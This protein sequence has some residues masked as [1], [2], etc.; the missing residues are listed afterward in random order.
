MFLLAEILIAVGSI[1]ILLLANFLRKLAAHRRRFKDLPKPPHSFLF[2]HI[3]LFIRANKKFSKETHSKIPLNVVVADI[4]KNYQLPDLFVFDLWPLVDPWLMTGD[5]KVANQFLN[6]Y[7]RHPM[8]LD[9]ALQ[10]L[11]GGKR[12]LVSHDSAEWHDARSVIRTVFSVNNVQRYIPSMARYSKQFCDSL[13]KRAAEGSSFPMI[14]PVENWGADLTFCFL[15]G[16]DTGVQMGGRGVETNLQVQA[17]ISQADHLFSVNLWKNYQQKRKRDQCLVSVRNLIETALK[18]ALK[19]EQPMT[20]DFLC[21]TDSLAMKYKEEFPDRTEWDEDTLIQHLDTLAT[22]FLAADVSSMVLTYIFCHIAQDPEVATQ[23]REEHDAVFPGDGNATLRALSENP[24]KIKELHYTTAVIKESMRLRPPG[25]AGTK[26]PNGQTT[27]H[28][29]TEFNLDGFYVH[30]NPLP[31]SLLPIALT[32]PAY[33]EPLL[34]PSKPLLCPIP[35]DIRPFS[36]APTAQHRVGN[37]LFS[38]YSLQ[39]SL[40]PHRLA[41]SWRPF[42]RGQHSC[43]GENMMMPG[44]ILALLLTVRDIDITLAYEEDDV[45]LG[46]ELGGKAYMAGNFAAKPAR[47]LPV[48]V[49]AR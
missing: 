22:L 9:A 29:G 34:S 7:R 35:R 37:P 23:L 2:G 17:L 25:T 33:G 40:T 46:P 18:D 1:S 13:L 28:N 49:T 41:D 36:L 12:G 26:A 19:R 24:S 30:L 14:E 44:L 3:L 5:R 48:V 8:V 38:P 45:D 11:S 15:L 16:E 43:M 4:Q 27:T 20:D 31:H 6:D 47:G 42:Q 10:P 32:R 21:L 39:I